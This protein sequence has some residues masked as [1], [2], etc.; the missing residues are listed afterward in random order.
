[1]N[2][3]KQNNVIILAKYQ[4]V[5]MAGYVVFWFQSINDD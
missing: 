2:Q 3:K 4:L 5:R 1:M